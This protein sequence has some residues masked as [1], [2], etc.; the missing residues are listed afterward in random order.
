MRILR[1]ALSDNFLLI[2]PCN[3]RISAI[4]EY[5]QL[6][7]NCN[8]RISA[9]TKNLQLQSICNY[10]ISAITKYLQLH[11]ICNHRISAITEYHRSHTMRIVDVFKE[12]FFHHKCSLCKKRSKPQAPGCG[13]VRRPLCGS[14]LVL[15]WLEQDIFGSSSSEGEKDLNGIYVIYCGF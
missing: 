6:Q 9:F 10:R 7:N 2:F 5:L 3:H 11:N 14:I 4:T 1:R 13:R 12:L 8:R 15:R